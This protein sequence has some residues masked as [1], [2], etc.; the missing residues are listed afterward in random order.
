MELSVLVNYQVGGKFYDGV[1]AGLMGLSYGSAL[2]TDALNAWTETN[3]NS[4]IPRL[5]ISSTSFFTASS[6]RWLTDASY[7]TI[8]NINLSYKLPKKYISKLDLSNVRVFAAGEN[9]ALFSSRKGL[10]PAESFNG[11]N[12]NTYTPSRMVTFGLGINL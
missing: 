11:V 7:L 10:N 1:Y 2:H 3:T 5:D 6:T 9:L 4:P 8:S 12:S